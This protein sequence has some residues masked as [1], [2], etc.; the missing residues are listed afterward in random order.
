MCTAQD[1]AGE[2]GRAPA[3]WAPEDKDGSECDKVKSQRA[4][5]RA[6]AQ[7]CLHCSLCSFS[8]PL[9]QVLVSWELQK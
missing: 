5:S 7:P 6:M 1:E 8:E 9:H 2:R 3:G 4:L